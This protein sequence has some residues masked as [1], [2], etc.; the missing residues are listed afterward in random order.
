M[1][2]VYV[3]RFYTEQD[4]FIEAKSITN[5]YGDLIPVDVALDVMLFDKTIQQTPLNS[6]IPITSIYISKIE[7]S[8]CWD[9]SIGPFRTEEEAILWKTYLKQRGYRDASTHKID[10][11]RKDYLIWY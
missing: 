7:S 9:V 6:N 8:A 11:E 10:K 5:G 2:Y 3:N 4:V 1:F